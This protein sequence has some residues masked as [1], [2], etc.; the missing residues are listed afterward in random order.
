MGPLT[1]YLG[2]LIVFGTI[3]IIHELGHFLVAKWSGMTVHEF[4]IGFGPI[5]FS[6]ISRGTRYSLRLLPLGGFVRIAGMEPGE[7]EEPNGFYTKPFFAKF[8]TIIAGVTMNIILALIIFIVMGMAIG[9]PKPVIHAIVAKM[10]AAQAG[11]QPNDRIVKIAGV[12]NPD[13][14]EAIRLINSSTPPVDVVVLRGNKRITYSVTPIAMKGEPGKKIGVN[15]IATYE[16]VGL[17]ESVTKGFVD[18]FE[19][20]HAMIVGIGMMI[21]GKAPP[22]S[23][24]GGVGIGR[25]IYDAAS[26]AFQNMEKMRWFLALFALISLN[27]AIVNLLPIPALDGSH[28]VILTI[29]RIRGKEFNPEK[30]A[31]VHTV[32]LILLLGLIVLIA[33]H[34]I[35]NWISGKPPIP[36]G[37]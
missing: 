12:E 23:F 22:G 11:M 16:K 26:T 13:I 28:L 34:D 37:R 7:E 9:R 10:P 27:I 6:R 17:G 8:A 15:L 2:I 30:K 33:G 14:D 20:T 4:S 31:I 25:I 1:G 5:L 32:G 19:A 29:E 24:T 3:I 35:W 36:G 18:T 21:T